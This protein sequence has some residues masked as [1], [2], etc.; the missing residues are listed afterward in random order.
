MPATRASSI[1][2]PVSSSPEQLLPDE[3]MDDAEHH[4]RRDHHDPGDLDP[5]H[6]VT[7]TERVIATAAPA[8]LSPMN[9][10]LGLHRRAGVAWVLNM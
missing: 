8:T 9:P 2:A 1:A 10:S 5:V 3:Q 7:G 4:A 6:L